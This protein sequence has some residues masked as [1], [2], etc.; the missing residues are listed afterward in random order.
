MTTYT[1]TNAA[2]TVPVGGHGFGHTKKQA[3]GT[4]RV[5]ASLAATDTI[6][7]CRVPKG[8]I[9][10]GGRFF[11]SRMEAT[12]STQ[13]LDFDLGWEDNGTDSVDTDGLGNFGPTAT[14]AVTGVKPE[15]DVFMYPL[16]GV[17]NTTG[18]KTLAAETIITA[19]VVASATSWISGMV[20][21]VV[22]YEL[23]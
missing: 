2:A 8:A 21:C 14:A 22:D 19:T 13:T 1:A 10:T 4:Y 17:L 11:G 20:G 3:Y 18:P 7:L 16:A 9:I 5:S 6:R 23:P 12:A 15:A